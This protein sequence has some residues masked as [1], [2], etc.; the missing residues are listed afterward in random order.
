MPSHK[1]PLLLDNFTEIPGAKYPIL[2][3]NHC[4]WSQANPTRAL[5][6]LGPGPDQCPGYKKLHEKDEASDRPPKRQQTLQFGIQTISK[7]KQ[8][9]LDS[10]TAMTVYVGAR[11]FALW[12]CPYMKAFIYFLS[13]QAYTPPFRQ[14]ISD[15]LLIE[16]YQGVRGKVL[17]I[18]D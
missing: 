7:A 8:E 18:F 12:E 16:A 3:C 10:L 14:R 13:D 5:K 17:V 15:K 1:N 2:A 4:K 9:K 6:H 11:P